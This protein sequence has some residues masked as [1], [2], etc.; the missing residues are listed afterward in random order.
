M[1]GFQKVERPEEVVE[2]V[3]KA[4]KQQRVSRGWSQRRLAQ[5][6]GLDPKTVSLIE[7]GLRSPTLHTLLQMA[8]A[9]ERPFWEIL[10]VAEGDPPDDP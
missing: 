10:K 5:A 1:A 2:L 4:L 7:R 8:S 9:L 6:A 3:I